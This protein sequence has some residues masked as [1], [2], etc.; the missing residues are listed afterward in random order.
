MFRAPSFF[1]RLARWRSTVRGLMPSVRQ[2][3]TNEELS[4]FETGDLRRD[5]RT[6]LE[7]GQTMER[8]VVPSD[9]SAQYLIASCLIAVGIM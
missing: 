4:Y 8:S 5:I 6:V 7:R 1:S 3:S 9:K 2:T